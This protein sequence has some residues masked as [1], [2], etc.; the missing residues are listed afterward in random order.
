MRSFS[1]VQRRRES[2]QWGQPAGGQWAHLAATYN[3][4]ILTS[5]G[6]FTIGGNGVWGEYFNGRIDEV[7]VYNRELTLSEITADM[8]TPIE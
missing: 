2:G 5:T 3:G 4:S 8:K 6:V 7:R 1:S